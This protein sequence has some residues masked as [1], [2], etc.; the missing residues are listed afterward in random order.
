VREGDHRRHAI[1]GASAHCVATHASDLAVAL[2]ALDATVRLHRASGERVVPL[3]AF[4]LQPG[5]HPERETVI[6]DGE[7][8]AAIEIPRTATARRSR[9][10]KLRDRATFDFALV[11][12]AA[13]LQVE[14]GMIGDVR[15][16]AGGVGTIPWRLRASEA[17]LAGRRCDDAALQDAAKR[18]ADGARPLA[19]NAYKVDLLT[20]LVRRVLEDLS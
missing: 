5:D 15:L 9:Y 8:I 11:S 14:D 3:T 1:F 7:L 18:A 20:R 19:H 12:V 10:L 17:A 2:A 6:E 4:Y 16:A 13:A